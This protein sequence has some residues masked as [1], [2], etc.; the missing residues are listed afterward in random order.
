MRLILEEAEKATSEAFQQQ[1]VLAGAV[2]ILTE[3]SFTEDTKL[4]AWAYHEMQS[5]IYPYPALKTVIWMN[6]SSDLLWFS[7]KVAFI[8]RL[9]TLALNSGVAIV[10]QGGF[11]AQFGKSALLWEVRFKVKT[12]YII[13]A[14]QQRSEN[15]SAMNVVFRWELRMFEDE[16]VQLF[17]GIPPYLSWLPTLSKVC[18]YGLWPLS[19]RG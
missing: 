6:R 12:P 11:E 4:R 10:S 9:Q 13:E 5:S 3:R 15:H 16:R 18:E 7:E 14:V 1:A 2:D 17:S 8:P 19:D